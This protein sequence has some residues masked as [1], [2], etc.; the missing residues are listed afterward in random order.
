MPFKH[1]PCIITVAPEPAPVHV[2]A[3]LGC[4]GHGPRPLLICYHE[5]HNDKFRKYFIV[6]FFLLY[7]FFYYYYFFLSIACFQQL[8]ETR[9]EYQTSVVKLC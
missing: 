7:F 6:F 4:F 1:S 2:K 5:A 9:T 3:Q 8:Q